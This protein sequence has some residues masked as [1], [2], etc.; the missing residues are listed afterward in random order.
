MHELTPQGHPGV[1]TV[2]VALLSLIVPTITNASQPTLLAQPADLQEVQNFFTLFFWL[3]QVYS[4]SRHPAVAGNILESCSA[5]TRCLRRYST[6]YRKTVRG[7]SIDILLLSKISLP[8]RGTVE[9]D[10]VYFRQCMYQVS[11]KHG[12]TV[13]G[14]NNSWVVPRRRARATLE[15]PQG[16][17]V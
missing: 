8:R 12:T 11:A 13:L 15:E 7:R 16:G 6:V 9:S 3:T 2:R 10:Q 4:R 5:A 14:N 17:N 1:K